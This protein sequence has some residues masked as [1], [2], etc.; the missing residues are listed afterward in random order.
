MFAIFGGV[1]HGKKPQNLFTSDRNVGVCQYLRSG[2]DQHNRSDRKMMLF[3]WKTVKC[4]CNFLKVKKKPSAS[5][6][7]QQPELMNCTFAWVL[8]RFL[9]LLTIYLSSR[10]H[11]RDTQT[12][13]D[14]AYETNQMTEESNRKMGDAAPQKEKERCNTKSETVLLLHGMAAS[15]GTG[16]CCRRAS[17]LLRM[18]LLMVLFPY[19]R[20]YLAGVPWRAD[21][22]G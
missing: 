22:G 8:H 15:W 2:N 20:W 17:L 7:S 16:L 11:H 13:Q 1:I 10:K 14:Q 4:L 5:P 9:M 12:S 19:W 18:V 6:K 3:T 21:F